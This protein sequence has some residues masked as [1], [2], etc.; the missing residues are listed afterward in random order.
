MEIKNQWGRLI[1]IYC[2]NV[3]TFYKMKPTTSWNG[4]F[5]TIIH[6]KQRG[7]QKWNIPAIDNGAEILY[8]GKSDGDIGGSLGTYG[9][10]LRTWVKLRI[11]QSKVQTQP[12]V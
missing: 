3:I 7:T 6:S 11:M 1:L 12:V 5:T 10:Y 9:I 2:E 8:V 4:T